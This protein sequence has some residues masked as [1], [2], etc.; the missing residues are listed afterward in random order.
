MTNPVFIS[1]TSEMSDCLSPLG[2]F[3]AVG[4]VKDAVNRC[5]MN[6]EEQDAT[7]FAEPRPPRQM[8]E[9]RV[10][11]CDIAVF[12][13]GYARGS[14]VSGAGKK[15]FVEH[16][17]DVAGNRKIPRIVLL[18]DPP[19]IPR[20]DVVNDGLQ[21]Q[22][23][24]RRKLRSTLTVSVFESFDEAGRLCEA[25]LLAIRRDRKPEPIAAPRRPFT[26]AAAGIKR[27]VPPEFALAMKQGL[28]AAFESA[29]AGGS[30]ATVSSVEPAVDAEPTP[31]LPTT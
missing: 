29:A 27:Q 12:V 18:W 8:C 22:L 19:F 14:P 1:H 25:A 3:S 15:T 26:S 7:F 2:T 31:D 5:Q 11:D 28:F 9:R 17:F 30:A 4:A 21:E 6:Y 10:A 16:E 20:R 23:A 24:F 13:I